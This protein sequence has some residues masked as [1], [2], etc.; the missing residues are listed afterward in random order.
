MR[1][2]KNK[3]ITKHKYTICFSQL[4]ISFCNLQTNPKYRRLLAGYH[5]YYKQ[6]NGVFSN[7][8]KYDIRDIDVA[9]IAFNSKRVALNVIYVRIFVKFFDNPCE[10]GKESNMPHWLIM[11]RFC[12]FNTTRTTERPLHWWQT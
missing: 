3:E 11:L 9:N 10:D 8:S 1:E 2:I 5:P 7:I 6:D 4:S 12:K